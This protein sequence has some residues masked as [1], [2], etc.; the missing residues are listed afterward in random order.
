MRVPALSAVSLPRLP[1]RG[2]WAAHPCAAGDGTRHAA[3]PR[4]PAV[5]MRHTSRPWQSWQGGRI[6]KINPLP[7]E[8]KIGN[9][10]TRKPPEMIR[11]QVAEPSQHP[12]AGAW[13]D[14]KLK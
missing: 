10:A 1:F 4:P 11:R 14:A 7:D 13:L 6:P 9:D 8:Q 5:L 12:S 2:R 3:K